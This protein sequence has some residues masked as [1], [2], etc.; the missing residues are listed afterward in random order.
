MFNS[1]SLH[2]DGRDLREE[3]DMAKRAALTD[4][5]TG[6]SN[7]SH[8]IEQLSAQL[9][10]VR[11]QN[12][13]CG[14]AILDLDFF[15]KIND[16]F[17]HPGGDIVLQHFS[18]TVRHTLR[19]EDGFGRIGGEEFLILLP[20]ICMHTLSAKIQHIID[21][22]PTERPLAAEPDFFYTCSIGGSLL[23][24]SDSIDS[25]ILR[26]DAALYQAKAEGRNRLIIAD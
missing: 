3:R 17:G 8:M 21:M 7:R 9:D 1:S 4:S 12:F 20:E 5:L 26:V 16:R 23:R 2:S 25:A 15:K 6:I 18:R 19:R 22:L 11:T 14:I 13:S 24:A 10:L